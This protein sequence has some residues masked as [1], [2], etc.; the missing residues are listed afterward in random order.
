MAQRAVA[1]ERTA[2]QAA[3]WRA[4]AT[5]WDRRLSTDSIVVMTSTD[6]SI[7]AQVLLHHVSPQARPSLQS[8]NDL[9]DQLAGMVSQAVATWPDVELTPL[10]FAQHVAAHLQPDVRPSSL[11]A[12]GLFLA[13]A[14]ARGQPK[15]LQALNRILVAMAQRVLP[16][17]HPS[18]AFHDEVLQTVRVKLLVGSE[19]SAP[20]IASYA[21]TGPLEGWLRVVVGRTALDLHRAR[22]PKVPEVMVNESTLPAD[23]I[24]D[25]ELDFIRR[26][27]REDFRAAF[28]AALDSLTDEERALLRLHVIN[29]MGID[30]LAVVLQVGRS[31]AARRL[32]AMRG[33]IRKQTQ[34]FLAQ[35]LQ[36]SPSEL[37]SLV[38]AM[39]S[40]VELSMTRVLE[41]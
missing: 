33:K 11:D 18:P 9:Q 15:A 17:V 35:R 20:R 36:M 16:S 31:T 19:S 26:E 24:T 10:D 39:Q 1:L 2:W 41:R 12:S 13:A 32:A 5:Q 7:L 4:G 8:M 14:C 34:R 38:R 40:Q 22:R 37:N 23:V 3:P 27:H 25:I 30:R 29:A 6:P 28:H 21:G